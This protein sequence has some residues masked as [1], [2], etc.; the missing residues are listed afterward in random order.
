MI[1]GDAVYDL[2]NIFIADWEFSGGSIE[3]LKKHYPQHPVKKQ[4][5]MQIA[6]SG[7]D[8]DKH[9]IKQAYFKMIATAKKNIYIESPYLV[10]E[11][12]LM[13][14]LKTAALSGVD[15]KIIIPYIA[16]H[17]MVYW[18]NQSN[19]Q[20]LLESNVEIYYYKGGFIHSKSLLVDDICASV[21]TANLDIRSMELNFEVNAF[22]YDESVVRDLR[23]DFEEDLYRSE[24]IELEEFK[25]RKSYRKVLE[26]F[27]RLVSPLQ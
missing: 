5:L 2:N 11:D 26:A 12:S 13:V 24:K 8:S 14:A 27:G 10:P 7:P 25:K 1:E 23:S 6:S 18:A 9:V 17:F 21:G 22:I 15:V 19:I 16:D 4:T 3:D 20:D